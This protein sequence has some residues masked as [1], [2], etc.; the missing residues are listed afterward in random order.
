VVEPDSAATQ[1]V[2]RVLAGRAG[3]NNPYQFCTGVYGGARRGGDR[4]SL[5][6]CYGR[7]G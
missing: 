2:V 7:S 1:Q 5:R 4:W 3:H 6:C